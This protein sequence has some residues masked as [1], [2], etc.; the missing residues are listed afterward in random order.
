MDDYIRVHEERVE[1]EDR[2][3]EHI[4]AAKVRLEGGREKAVAELIT[5]A[6]AMTGEAD[7]RDIL[8]R[9]GIR[10]EI[11]RNGDGQDHRAIAIAVHVDPITR[12]L[13]DTPYA[14]GYGAQLRRNGLSRGGKSARFKIGVH[15]CILLD[16]A[17]VRDKYLGADGQG[18]MEGME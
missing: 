11:Y 10:F 7:A 5:D 4:F 14:A 15:K 18:R 6:D 8:S 17:G 16:W 3:I 13:A 1:D 12:M 2:V 9:H